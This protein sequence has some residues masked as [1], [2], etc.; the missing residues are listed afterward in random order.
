MINQ[1]FA[2]DYL[3]N[4]LYQKLALLEMESKLIKIS[5]RLME[6]ELYMMEDA[7]EEIMEIIELI[8]MELQEV[9]CDIRDLK[10]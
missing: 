6:E 3:V 2:N 9:M 5:C 1:T 8:E 7:V 4:K 10:L